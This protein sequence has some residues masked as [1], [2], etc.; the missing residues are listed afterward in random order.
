MYCRQ[1]TFR[2]SVSLYPH[3]PSVVNEKIWS[4]NFAPYAFAKEL[5]KRYKKKKIILEVILNNLFFVAEADGEIASEEIEMLRNY[6]TIFGLSPEK[7][8]RIVDGKK[9]SVKNTDKKKTIL[10]DGDP[11]IYLDELEI[12]DDFEFGEE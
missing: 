8:A 3:A 4:K 9:E 10:D 11:Y 1:S 7:F 12:D 2:L 5:A 6:A